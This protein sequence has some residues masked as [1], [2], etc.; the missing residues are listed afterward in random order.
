MKMFQ[1]TVAQLL[2]NLGQT[3]SVS[4]GRRAVVQG[5]IRVNGDIVDDLTQ[6][7]DFKSSDF[8]QIGNNTPFCVGSYLGAT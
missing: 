3:T 7:F 6:I 1:G 5:A 8:I 2:A 4:E